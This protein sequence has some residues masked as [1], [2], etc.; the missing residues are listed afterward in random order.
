MAN[1]ECVQTSADVGNEQAGLIAAQFKYIK[2]LS[3]LKY[4]TEEKREQSLIQQSSQMQATF[5]FLTAAI[6]MVIPV[7][8]ENRGTLSLGFFLL[9]LS[10]IM[11]FLTASLVL[12]SLAQWRW[13]T[14]TFPDVEEIKR[15]VLESSDWKKLT[16]EYY[17]INQWIDLVAKI[18]KEKARLNNKRVKLI[19]ASMICLYCSIASIFLSFI[20]A[21]AKL[22]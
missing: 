2:E 12:A 18:Q 7:C 22:I 13:K 15:S 19:M 16:I 6:F 11:I 3:N 17:Q 1:E 14:Q 8:I 10:V 20:I 21:I 9:A 4:E 5:S